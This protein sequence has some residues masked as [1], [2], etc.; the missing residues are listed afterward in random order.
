LIPATPVTHHGIA[1][2]RAATLL[3]VALAGWLAATPVRAAPAAPIVVA[4][5]AWVRGTVEGQTGS[6]AYMRLTS[7]EDA[8]LVGAS[9]VVA[10]HVEIHE[11]RTVNDMM[12]MRRVDRLALPA[13]VTVA[14]DHEYHVMF[15]GLKH[16]LLPRQI[17]PITLQILDAAGRRHTV[18]IEAPVRALNS[19]GA[20]HG[21]ASPTATPHG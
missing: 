5:D 16:Q 7:S 10:E 3:G 18:Q 6:G 4:E 17:V 19:V 20:P 14:L 9:S 11:M 15:I 21:A 12:R 2:R 8:Q 13:H 1:L